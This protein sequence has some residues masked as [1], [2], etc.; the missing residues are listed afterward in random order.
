MLVRLI[1]LEGQTFE[2]SFEDDIT[3][4]AI[5]QKLL[6]EYS[7]NTDRCYFCQYG[8]ILGS[9]KI[10]Q[11]TFAQGTADN[12]IIIFNSQAFPDKSY[13][14]VDNAFNFSFSRYSENYINALPRVNKNQ[15]NGLPAHLISALPPNIP[16]PE[17]LR[18]G[19]IP[20]RAGQH[21]FRFVGNHNQSPNRNSA[22]TP[23][24]NNSESDEEELDRSSN[25]PIHRR[26]TAF[27]ESSIRPIR[28]SNFRDP[29]LIQADF[30]DF[31][32]ENPIE[33]LNNN[34][35]INNT[36]TIIITER[37]PNRIVRRIILRNPSQQ[38]EEQLLQ[39]RQIQQARQI[40]QIQQAQQMQQTQPPPPVPP[41]Q[42]EQQ[43]R[44]ANAA[45]AVQNQNSRYA[46]L[47][48]RESELNQQIIEGLH[49]NIRLNEEENR[50]ISRLSR[51]GYDRATV[52]QVYEACDRNEEAAMNL[53][54]SMG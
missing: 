51:A 20:D 37:Q 13:P 49:L 1:N 28:M 27:R 16:L 19:I 46:D 12:T 14:K 2:L 35:P 11:E 26:T 8:K 9:E 23:N 24:R 43:N 3:V 45:A 17:I 50:V 38:Q 10:P 25:S 6:K 29:N 44:P 52:I 48:R 7:Y 34:D 54:V 5:R 33:D 40:Q 30:D 18:L 4:Q 41:A 47:I 22:T 53:L 32:D 31:D 36:N 15:L 21:L 42:H 39:I